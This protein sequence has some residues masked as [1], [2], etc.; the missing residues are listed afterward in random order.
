[1]CKHREGKRLKLW[2]EIDKCLV[3]LVE[4][5]NKYGIETSSCCCGHGVKHNGEKI[6]NNI[7]FLTSNARLGIKDENG[8]AKGWVSPL[9]FNVWG[10][11]FS[12]NKNRGK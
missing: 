3:P 10:I 4:T 7:V 8:V 11:S 12:I 9:D 5:L 2:V 1:M 6:N